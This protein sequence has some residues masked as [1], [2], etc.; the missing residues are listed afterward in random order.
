MSDKNNVIPFKRPNR[1]GQD[2]QPQDPPAAGDSFNFQSFVECSMA[3]DDDGAARHLLHIFALSPER[4]RECADWFGQRARKDPAFVKEVQ[5]MRVH[6]MSNDTTSLMMSLYT[7][8][9]L[10]GP[11][12]V[13]IALRL[14]EMLSFGLR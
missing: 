9:G 10:Q 8:F 7:G 14:R 12:A 1:G 11:E 2:A 3:G 13:V 5:Q 6:L 4:S